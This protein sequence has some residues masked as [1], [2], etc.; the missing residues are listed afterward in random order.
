MNP[1]CGIRNLCYW[2]HPAMNDLF[3]QSSGLSVTCY[4]IVNL[5]QIMQQYYC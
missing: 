2:W 3:K 4:N 1:A 5:I